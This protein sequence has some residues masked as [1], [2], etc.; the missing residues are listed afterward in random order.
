LYVAG[1][2]NLKKLVLRGDNAILGLGMHTVLQSLMKQV[3]AVEVVLCTAAFWSWEHNDPVQSDTLQ[4]PSL[5]AIQ[6]NLYLLSENPNRLPDLQFQYVN[7]V[8]DSP[9]LVC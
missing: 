9:S 5:F 1:L 7:T 4:T 2:T 8:R 6:D 3:T